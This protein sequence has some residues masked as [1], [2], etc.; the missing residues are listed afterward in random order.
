TASPLDS[1][2]SSRQSSFLNANKLLNGD[3][4]EVVRGKYIEKPMHCPFC[5]N[6]FMRPEEK[7]TDVNISV[8]MQEDCIKDK[9]DTLVLVS[10]DS[11]LIPPLESISRN[12]PKKSIKVYFP[13]SRYSRDIKDFLYLQR[14]KPVLLEK[15]MKRFEDSIMP[16]TVEKG[17]KK[18]TIPEKWKKAMSL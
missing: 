11:D 9:T 17:D 8:R 12:F 10:A 4:F 1:E 15:N 2:K 14:K 3:I 5:H 7:K 6:D 18:Y 16:D 13:P